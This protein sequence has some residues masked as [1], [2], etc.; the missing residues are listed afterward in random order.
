MRSDVRAFHRRSAA[1]RS[2]TISL[3]LCLT[4]ALGC[5]GASAPRER[6]AGAKMGDGKKDGGKDP[7]QDISDKEKGLD[8][9]GGAEKALPRKVIYTAHADLVVEDFD[10]AEEEVG[11]LVKEHD[12]YVARSDVQGEPG[13]PRRGSWTVRVPAARFDAFR[14]ALAHLG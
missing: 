9:K 4:F 7:G 14:Q 6:G 12:A 11:R 13:T 8:E 3:A 5:G 2:V 10:R 1:M